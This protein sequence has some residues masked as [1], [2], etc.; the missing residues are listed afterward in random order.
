M[1][2]IISSYA[3]A[4]PNAIDGQSTFALEAY[5]AISSKPGNIIFSPYSISIAL[6]MTATG[7]DKKTLAEMKKALHLSDN[8]STDYKNLLAGVTPSKDYELLIAN[9]IWPSQAKSYYP[10]FTKGLKNNFNA[11]FAVLDYRKRPEHSRMT[12]NKWV[13][14][15]TKD[16]IKN[17]IPKG[18]I[19]D[20]TDIVLTNAIYFKGQW[21]EKFKKENTRKSDFFLN[22]TQ[23]KPVDF[24]NRTGHHGYYKDVDSQILEIPYKGNEISFI[25]ALPDESVDITT[26]EKSLTLNRL[27][28]WM[29]PKWQPE[30]ILALP[31]FKAELP[32]PLVPTLKSLGIVEAFDAHKATFT[33]IRQLGPKEN[34][35]V[36]DVIHKAFIEVN[37]EG[38][39]AAAATAVLVAKA[40]SI[41]KPIHFN[42]NRPFLY[43]I[44]HIPTNA[45]L[46]MGRLS[47]P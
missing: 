33:R 5:K 13:E 12:I 41:S 27:Q 37:E 3:F 47:K 32:L 11:D 19:T 16:K 39:E 17:L 30:V 42:A 8:F 40:T 23:K 45:V 38:T 24:M 1:V 26:F 31:K 35:S 25:V 18:G 22:K 44:R 14:E 2:L 9:R 21:L 46:F 20:R 43:F 15:K 34:L 10:Q 29:R 28:A 4:T 6:A 7:A 36:S